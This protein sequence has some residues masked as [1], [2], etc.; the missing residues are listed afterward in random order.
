MKS[1]K[2]YKYKKLNKEVKIIN[3]IGKIFQAISRY[4]PIDD[5]DKIDLGI[6]LIKNYQ[7]QF[8]QI[9]LNK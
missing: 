1:L 6:T 4:K 2:N 3:E 5:R 9:N 7:Q 8:N